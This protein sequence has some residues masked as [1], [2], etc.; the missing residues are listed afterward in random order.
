ML[1]SKTYQ[2]TLDYDPN[3][4]NQVIREVYAPGGFTSYYFNRVP[5]AGSLQGLRGLGGFSSLPQWGQIAL[6]AGISVVVGYFGMAKFGKSH[7]K[8]ALRKIGI[9]R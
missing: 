5:D 3:N 2:Q 9:G 8:P 7:I 6:V 1:I 4:P